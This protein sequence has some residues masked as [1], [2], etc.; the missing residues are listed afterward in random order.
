MNILILSSMTNKHFLEDFKL[1]N[2]FIAHGH[3]VMVA[4]INQVN[5]TMNSVYDVVL[6]RNFVPEDLS[7]LDSVKA[8]YQEKIAL[9]PDVTP[10]YQKYNVGLYIDVSLALNIPLC[11][12]TK[13]GVGYNLTFPYRI[14]STMDNKSFVIQKVYEK[15]YHSVIVDGNVV[16]T[17]SES[18]GLR[19]V[20]TECNKTIES[21]ADYLK[22]QDID[23]AEV[24]YVIDDNGNIMLSHIDATHVTLDNRLCDE[25][26]LYS[27]ILDVIERKK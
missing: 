15:Y 11:E 6:F 25:N 1:G 18:K 10:V 22:S 14:V 17:F 16:Y 3:N 19:K 13:E 12:R 21:I 23:M 2:Y 24:V 9:I 20:E 4:D 27:R 7:K 5:S 8:L 26:K